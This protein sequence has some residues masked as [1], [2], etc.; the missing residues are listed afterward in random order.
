MAIDS[1]QRLRIPL[2][3][4]S[5]I[6]TIAI[7]AI[8]LRSGVT[9]N[10]FESGTVLSGGYRMLHGDVLYR[11][12]FAF[13]GPLVYLIPGLAARLTPG[14]AGIFAVG[15]LTGAGAS[16]AQYA[17]VFRLSGRRYAALIVPWGLALMGANTARTLP[18]LCGYLC[19]CQAT[20]THQKRWWFAVG[21][22]AGVGLIWWQDGGVFFLLA[23]AVG[24]ASS[25]RRA[26]VS[27]LSPIVTGRLIS[28]GI[29]T[30][31]GPF[32]VLFAAQGAL[33]DW[34]Y[35]CFI[36]PNT[37]YVHRSATGY[38]V[39]LVGSW[40]GES[41]TT[42]I[43]HVAFYL[44][45]YFLV[46]AMAITCLFIGIRITFRN[47]DPTSIGL[48]VLAVY[49]FLQLRV[50]A[51]SIDEA[52]LADTCAGVVCCAGGLALAALRERKGSSYRQRAICLLTLIWMVV[53]PAQV[54]VHHLENVPIGSSSEFEL[55]PVA[56][57]SPPQ[58][59]VHE[60]AAL[61]SAVDSLTSG[62]DRIFVSPTEPYMYLL[63]LHRP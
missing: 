18:A 6:P 15:V 25:F 2:A 46:A 35:Y 54:Y 21:L 56:G 36:F 34:L 38:I 4:A 41:L 60:L 63:R 50:L 11:D 61:R 57:A 16:M 52:K 32:A 14:L 30:V 29:A 23:L 28:L 22:S 9:I 24:I 17:T 48:M 3:L 13:Y 19:I 44:A 37:T 27:R 59:S 53:W 43:Y 58:T 1:N 10:L 40:S 42:L 12:I 55:L 31:V 45:P 7:S 20:R 62:R 26:A 47:S 49:S 8:T 5:T 51:S 33:S 39:E